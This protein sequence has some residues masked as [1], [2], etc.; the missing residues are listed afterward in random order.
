MLRLCKQERT[1]IAAGLNS[2]LS[3]HC[4]SP[5]AT[6]DV[7]ATCRSPP[8]SRPVRNGR[9]RTW[10]AGVSQTEPVSG[11]TGDPDLVLVFEL[12]GFVDAYTSAADTAKSTESIDVVDGQYLGAFNDR[13]EVIA[14]GTDELVRDRYPDRPLRPCETR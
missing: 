11:S 7:G 1:G 8:H 2:G 3:C 13:G 4:P 9:S 12:E 6:G 10:E 5:C 14:M